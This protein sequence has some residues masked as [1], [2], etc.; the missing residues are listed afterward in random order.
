L[1]ATKQEEQ[2]ELQDPLTAFMYGLKA[3]D[4]KR[5]RPSRLKIFLDYLSLE[6]GTLEEKAKQFIVKSR[7]SP[8]WA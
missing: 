4:T 6:H 7:Q 5:Q 2:Y 8:Q 1:I 3:P